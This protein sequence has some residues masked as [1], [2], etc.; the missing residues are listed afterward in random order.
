MHY[1]IIAVT[2]G[3]AIYVANM[4]VGIVDIAV[5][6]PTPVHVLATL[7]GG[8]VLYVVVIALVVKFIASLLHPE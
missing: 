5:P 4:I 8:Y 1:L 3:A 7:A 6:L 2:A